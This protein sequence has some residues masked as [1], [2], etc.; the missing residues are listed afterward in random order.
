VLPA[1]E[2]EDA[3]DWLRDHLGFVAYPQVSTPQGQCVVPKTMDPDPRIVLAAGASVSAC[4][5]ERRPGIGRGSPWSNRLDF[6][7]DGDYRVRAL[8]TLGVIEGAHPLPADI[9]RGM[10]HGGGVLDVPLVEVKPPSRN[11]LDLPETPDPQRLE[12]ERQQRERLALRRKRV[13][14]LPVPQAVTLHSGETAFLAGLSS[15]RPPAPEV[16]VEQ[17]IAQGAQV[18]LSLGA[19]QGIVVG[20]IFG[21]QGMAGTVRVRVERVEASWSQAA[22]IVDQPRPSLSGET[23][24]LTWLLKNP[25]PHL[26]YRQRTV[27]ATPAP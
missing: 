26:L 25:R 4:W 8:V 12:E 5:E 19:A 11:L 13:A 18:R 23:S 16:E 6:P 9:D 2:K 17:V 22:L 7:A 27:T 20:D 3:V 1:A 15:T 14:E 21:M 10:S 24:V